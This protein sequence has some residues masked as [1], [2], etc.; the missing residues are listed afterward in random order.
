MSDQPAQP[1]DEPTSSYTPSASYAY[2]PATVP[3]GAAAVEP[4][5]PAA[6]S[7]RTRWIVGGVVG[8]LAIWVFGFFGGVA[9]SEVFDG[10]HDFDG[11]GSAEIHGGLPLPGTQVPG[12]PGAPL[13]GDDDSG[14][15]DD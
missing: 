7:R 4:V 13:P 6:K 9:A 15:Y 3:P 2:E 5:A 8:A 10:G 1:N 14:A 12:Q 11:P